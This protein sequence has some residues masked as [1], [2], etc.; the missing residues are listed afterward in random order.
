M[1]VPLIERVT[2]MWDQVNC[3][4]AFS[5]FI[6][7][8]SD[9]PPVICLA[10][11]QWG[12]AYFRLIP[13]ARGATKNGKKGVHVELYRPKITVPNSGG[14]AINLIQEGKTGGPYTVVAD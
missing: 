4:D 3:M 5:F 6:E 12:P 10:D 2:I 14:I 7:T 13:Y 11:N 1:G 9:R 8:G